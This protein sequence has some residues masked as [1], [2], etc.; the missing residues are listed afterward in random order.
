MKII[1]T[2][3][4]NRKFVETVTEYLDKS[5]TPVY[6]WDNHKLYADDLEE[7]G[8]VFFHLEDDTDFEIWYTSCDN[9]YLSE[10]LPKGKCPVA[11]I[12]SNI[13]N[14]LEGFFGSHWMPIFYQWF[15][16]HTGLPVNVVDFEG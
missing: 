6:G 10:P 13:Y 3:A 12:P 14:S 16:H 15:E 4:Q 5:L 11:V 7:E 8:E 1:I 9:P 2:E